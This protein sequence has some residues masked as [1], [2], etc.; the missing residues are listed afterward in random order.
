ML[1]IAADATY[2]AGRV[3]NDVGKGERA[4]Q[5]GRKPEPCNGQDLVQALREAVGNT[6]RVALEAMPRLFSALPASLSS[7]AWRSTRRAENMQ[8]FRQIAP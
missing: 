2:R 3:L 5:L 7:Q 4:P 8:R 1:H 6:G